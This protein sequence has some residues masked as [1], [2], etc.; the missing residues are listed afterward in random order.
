MSHCACEPLRGGRT[1]SVQRPPCRTLTS[2]VVPTGGR[3]RRTARAS[4]LVW[5]GP[6]SVKAASTPHCSLKNVVRAHR[7]ATTGLPHCARELP[8]PREEGR[9]G[10]LSVRRTRTLPVACPQGGAALLH[11]TARASPDGGG[12]R[13]ARVRLT[14]ALLAILRRQGIRP[15]PHHDQ[16]R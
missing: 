9:C 15:T 2:Y 16:L 13:S 6:R 14:P 4:P 11:R 3:L 5:G 8:P 12:V 1:R 10:R 7:G